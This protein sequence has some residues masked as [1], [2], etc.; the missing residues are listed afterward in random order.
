M[1]DYKKYSQFPSYVLQYMKGIE[2]LYKAP[3]YEDFMFNEI[4]ISPEHATTF[5]GFGAGP[6]ALVTYSVYQHTG[7]IRESE[8]E[9]Y[10][11]PEGDNPKRVYSF[12]YITPDT[13]F[14][15]GAPYSLSRFFGERYA[16][17][18]EES[19]KSIYQAEYKKAYDKG[20]EDGLKAGRKEGYDQA[21]REDAEDFG[22]SAEELEEMNAE[23]RVFAGDPDEF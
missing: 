1:V 15:A 2:A 13:M 22:P 4:Y 7:D 23:F 18:T 8:G 16:L 17:D 3:R 6:C 20:H 10:I 19:A 5:K 9:R 11:E 21:R 12:A 14:A